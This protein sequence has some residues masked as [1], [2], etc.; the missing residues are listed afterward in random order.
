MKS[1]YVHHEFKSLKEEKDNTAVAHVLIMLP[2]IT[3]VQVIVG[4]ELN[5]NNL[6]KSARNVCGLRCWP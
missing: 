2:P 5:L 1:V 6:V 4:H 3:S